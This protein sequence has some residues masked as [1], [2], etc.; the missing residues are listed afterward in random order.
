[1]NTI[2]ETL[3]EYQRKSSVFVNVI[4]SVDDE[5]IWGIQEINE[6]LWRHF[7]G[8]WLLIKPCLAQV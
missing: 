6:D 1:M 3:K 5:T 2:E 7:N 8:E 4:N